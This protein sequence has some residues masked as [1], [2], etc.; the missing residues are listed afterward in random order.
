MARMSL[1]R[2]SLAAAVLAAALGSTTV[3]ASA[4]GSWYVV[5]CARYVEA[6]AAPDGQARREGTA[7][8]VG[9]TEEVALEQAQGQGNGMSHHVGEPC[10]TYGPMGRAAAMSL[11]GELEEH[12]DEP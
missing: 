10:A 4:E 7:V 1:G 5:S 6:G 3:A 12:R 2:R 11:S 9:E 8:G